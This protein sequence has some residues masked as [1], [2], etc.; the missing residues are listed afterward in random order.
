MRL[1]DSICPEAHGS[2]GAGHH[3]GRR[4]KLGLRVEGI[5]APLP[6]KIEC[7]SRGLDDGV[8]FGSVDPRIVRAYQLPP[9][10]ISHYDATR[11]TCSSP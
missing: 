8:A 10:M 5:A 3:V 6:T 2:R 4:W 7:S 9:L 1:S 11:K